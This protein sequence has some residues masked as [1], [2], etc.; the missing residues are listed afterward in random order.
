M[1]DKFKSKQNLRKRFFKC[2]STRQIHATEMSLTET[3]RI[4]I[5]KKSNE[6]LVE[7]HLLMPGLN[8]VTIITSPLE[9]VLKPIKDVPGHERWFTKINLTCCQI[10]KASPDV[11]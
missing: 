1:K 5:W 11:M 9:N 8:H 4:V 10:E 3:K 7:T 6:V 2:L